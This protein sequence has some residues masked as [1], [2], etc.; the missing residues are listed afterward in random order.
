MSRCLTVPLSAEV[1][2]RFHLGDPGK[3][4]HGRARSLGGF[5]QAEQKPTKDFLFFYL[6]DLYLDL[7]ICV[8]LLMWALFPCSLPTTT[9][10]GQLWGLF[11]LLRGL[12]T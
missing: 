9:I 6:L 10:P 11:M 5:T 4:L 2:L 3:W 12:Q 8:I 1:P 7:P